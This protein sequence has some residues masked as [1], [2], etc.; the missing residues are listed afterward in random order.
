TTS[1][2]GPR[3][4]SAATGRAHTCHKHASACRAPA[5]TTVAAAG[6]PP[7]LPDGTLGSRESGDGGGRAAEVAL[8]DRGVAALELALHRPERLRQRAGARD[9]ARAEVEVGHEAAQPQHR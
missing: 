3:P 1:Y 4:A 7:Y 5:E 6:D 2:C 8:G 9:R